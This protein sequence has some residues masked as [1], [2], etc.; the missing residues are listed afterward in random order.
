M[1]L[2]N[3]AKARLKN[4]SR[5]IVDHEEYAEDYGYSSDSDLEDDEDEKAASIKQK[6]K[7]KVHLFDPYEIPG[8]GRRISCEEHDEHTGQVKIVKIPDV[9][10]VT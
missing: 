6:S 4:S 7:L 5:E 1:L 8:E 2:G 9:A 3:P 10:F